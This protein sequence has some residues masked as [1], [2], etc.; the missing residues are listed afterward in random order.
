[1]PAVSVR[2][3]GID[4]H[5]LSDTALAAGARARRARRACARRTRAAAR[6]ARGAGSA[7]AARAAAVAAGA[8]ARSATRGATAIV[9]RPLRIAWLEAG[10]A[11]LRAVRARLAGVRR[12]AGGAHVVGLG[13]RGGALAA[14]GAAHVVVVAAGGGVGVRRSRGAVVRAAGRAGRGPAHGI[15]FG[16]VDRGGVIRGRA[17]RAARVRAARAAHGGA[18]AR[19]GRRGAALRGGCV[20]VGLLVLHVAHRER[21]AARQRDDG[22]QNERRCKLAHHASYVAMDWWLLA[23][24]SLQA[25]CHALMRS[26][27]GQLGVA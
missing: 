16:A 14:L 2:H 17:R 6:G 9:L 4:R 23:K 25:A 22:S 21:G 20:V 5:A 10:A 26:F 1:M 11:G 13:G 15:R 24:S 3:V 7:R 18:G 12:R 8:R 19:G 27:G